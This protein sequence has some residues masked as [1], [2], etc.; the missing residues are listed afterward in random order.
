MHI[1][2]RFAYF[3][4]KSLFSD[5]HKHAWKEEEREITCWLCKQSFAWYTFLSVH[6]HHATYCVMQGARMEVLLRKFE[7]TTHTI[8]CIS[9]S[10]GSF[11]FEK[12]FLEV[13]YFYTTRKIFHFLWLTF[14]QVRLFEMWSRLLSSMFNDII[15]LVEHWILNF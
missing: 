6:Y 3:C 9:N 14:N 15:S 2:C 7:C 13:V 12:T 5:C 11:Q 8:L 1:K 4:P 10:V